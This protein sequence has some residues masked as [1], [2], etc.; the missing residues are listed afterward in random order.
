MNHFKQR[1]VQSEESFFSNN[2]K[3]VT[4][5]ICRIMSYAFCIYPVMLLLN[6]IN[7]F[8]FSNRV[9]F[10]IFVV[11]IFCT[12]SPLLLS[13][14]VKNQTFMKYYTLLCIITVVSVLG[15]EYYVGIYITYI[16]A[17]I[18]SCLYFDKKFTARILSISY[19]AFLISYFFRSFQIRDHLYPTE[20]IPQ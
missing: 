12:L 6:V 20:T 16:I 19:V 9:I 7:L 4:Q 8:K 1:S 15:T 10:L 5:M 13:R 3:E 11:G 14:F 2:E 18:A 17:P